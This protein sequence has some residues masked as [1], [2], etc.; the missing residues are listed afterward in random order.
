MLKA[1][2]FIAGNY[3]RVD[4]PLDSTE[5]QERVQRWRKKEPWERSG[6]TISVETPLMPTKR[7]QQPPVIIDVPF[8]HG[9]ICI[10]L[11]GTQIGRNTALIE[12]M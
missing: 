9:T 2:K 4:S 3:D 11:E 10:A 7:P 8:S 6:S 12:F 5:S 1:Y